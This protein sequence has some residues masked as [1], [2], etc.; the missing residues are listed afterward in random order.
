M[1]WSAVVKIQMHVPLW[2]SDWESRRLLDISSCV[3]NNVH[4][5]FSVKY[6]VLIIYGKYCRRG[7]GYENDDF[8][9]ARQCVYRPICFWRDYPSYSISVIKCQNYH[10]IC[11]EVLF[12]RLLWRQRLL[13]E[14]LVVDC[15]DGLSAR[16]HSSRGPF[17]RGPFLSV[18][19][20]VI[21]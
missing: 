7:I 18:G 8:H 13:G 21:R 12:I 20:R 16:K 9:L 2:A 3:H 1:V 5:K 6:C 10:P 4:V 17:P 11:L 15:G 14:A 19:I